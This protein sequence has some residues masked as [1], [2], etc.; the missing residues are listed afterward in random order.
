MNSKD[1]PAS[2]S[3]QPSATFPG[4]APSP[5]RAAYYDEQRQAWQVF[6]YYE[7]QRVLSDYTVFT[8]N[9]DRLDSDANN[10]AS[11]ANMI[12]LDP[13]RHN[14]LRAL[15]AQAFTPK[16]VTE[17]EPA[18]TNLAHQ[19]L[20]VVIDQGEMDAVK[21]FAGPL[22]LLVINRLL[23]VPK[24][25]QPQVRQWCMAYAQMNTPAARQARNDLEDYFTTLQELRR[26]DPQDDLVSA[27]LTAQIDGQY[28][29][30]PEIAGSCLLLIIAGNE[31]TKNLIGNALLCF[32]EYP[33]AMEQIYAQP[34]LLPSAIEEV[35]R[36]LPPT[37]SFPRIARVD[38]TIEGQAVK[39]GQW[40][41]PWMMS[42]NRDPEV[43][44][45]PNRFDIQRNPNRH[46]SFGS[47][48]HFCLGAPLAR[49]EARIALSTIFERLADIQRVR[50][51]PLEPFRHP[52]IYGVHHLPLT[53]RKR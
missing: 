16:A 23:G 44:S 25:D 32:D 11:S 15:V 34:T 13:P 9:R 50:T 6:R 8:S 26:K 17:L 28:L 4:F 2:S 20:D 33:D 30:E 10:V 45:D 42:A 14:Q 1:L 53:F 19:L 36:Y 21:D 52:M 47:G 5:G 27:L 18:I 35:L 41:T 12:N 40:V 48:V 29:T 49:L 38:T 7:V 43:F 46:I 3:E 31:T 22:P 24:E 37:P 39:A 51:I